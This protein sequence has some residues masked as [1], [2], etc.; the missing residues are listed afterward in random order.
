MNISFEKIKNLIPGI[1]TSVFMLI[2]P[3]IWADDTMMDASLMPRQ[4]ALSVFLIAS[5]PIMVI[6]AIKGGR[7]SFDRTESVIFGGMALFML[8]HIVSCVNV[9]NGHEA[10]FFF[11]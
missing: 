11:V 6:Y 3:T 2:I 10:F 4:V 9:I 1:L 8:M 5:I 7:F